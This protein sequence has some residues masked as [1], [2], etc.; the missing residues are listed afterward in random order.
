LAQAWNALAEQA[1]LLS[2]GTHVEKRTGM[3][4]DQMN[5]LLKEIRSG[6]TRVEAF[7]LEGRAR[8]LLAVNHLSYGAAISLLSQVVIYVGAWSRWCKLRDVNGAQ[9]YSAVVV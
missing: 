7:G 4:L 8:V 6:Y 1:R 2:R 5:L 9:G 3:A